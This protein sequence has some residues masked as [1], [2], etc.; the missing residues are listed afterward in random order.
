[1]VQKHNAL[2]TLACLIVL[3]GTAHAQSRTKQ[4]DGTEVVVSWSRDDGTTGR[5]VNGVTDVTYL[6]NITVT[7]TR[8]GRRIDERKFEASAKGSIMEEM[9][10][11]GKTNMKVFRPSFE[12]PEITWLKEH[13]KVL[14]S[15]RAN[16][17]MPRFDHPDCGNGATERKVA[18][19][20]ETAQSLSTATAMLR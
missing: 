17:K 9:D 1:M 15:V 2:A 7:T 20:V 14:V 18:R 13:G 12:D 6:M 10:C 4:Y 16:I 3:T 11:A 5:T 19:N 8:D